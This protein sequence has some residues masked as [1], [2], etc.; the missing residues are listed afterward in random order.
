[1]DDRLKALEKQIELS[2]ANARRAKDLAKTVE[3][4][5]HSQP[6]EHAVIQPGNAAAKGRNWGP[7]QATGPPDT[8][9]EGD[10]PTAWASL[11]QDAGSEWL[12]LKYDKVVTVA[13][14]KVRQ[15]HNAGA[16]SKVTLM[17]PSGSET[18]IWQGQQPPQSG[19]VEASFKAP[20]GVQSQQVVVYLDTSR[21]SGWNEI[22]AVELVA[23]DGKRYWASSAQASSSFAD[24]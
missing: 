14:V 18:T 24:R 15:T 23:T 20:A 17:S 2:D 16:I 4:L 1:M 21:V 9:A 5:Q 11:D 13:E 7:E 10:V 19:V 3:Q 12:L 6:A 8:V 22:D